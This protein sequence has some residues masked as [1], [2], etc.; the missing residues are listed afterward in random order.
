[1]DMHAIDLSP[2]ALPRCFV[3][4]EAH[5]VVMECSARPGEPR[6]AH[7]FAP[8]ENATRLP[9]LLDRAIEVLELNCVAEQTTS[10]SAIFGHL[11]V[12]IQ[13]IAGTNAPHTAVTIGLARAA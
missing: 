13:L 10:R 8:S 12:K 7:Y 2:S 6:D 5:R 3:I 11:T 1:M 4:D 9:A